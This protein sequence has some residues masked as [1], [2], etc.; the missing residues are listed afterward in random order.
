VGAPDHSVAGA[1]HQGA[2]YAFTRFG[3]VWLQQQEI[4]ASDGHLD[5]IF[6]ADVAMDSSTA[7]IKGGD[8]GGL[9][10]FRGAAY[11]FALSGGLWFEQQKLTADDSG[12]GDD[13]GGSLA[14]SGDTLVVGAAFDDIGANLSQG[15]VYVFIRTGSTWTLQQKLLA[16]DGA[17]FDDLGFDVA[18]S[19]DTIIAG[20]PGKTLPAIEE[21]GAA[22]V[23]SRA[24]TVWTQQQKLTASDAGEADGFGAGVA[25]SDVVI[26]GAPGHKVGSNDV[27]GAAYVF[28]VP[29]AFDFCMQDDSSGKLLRLNSKTGDYEFLDCRNGS[30]LSG[31]GSIA[32][33]SC[34]TQLMDS[35]TDPKHPDRLVS[36]LVNTCTKVASATVQTF[37]PVKKTVSLSDANITNN[38]CACQ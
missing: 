27:E 30:R 18:I 6:G 4:T 36:A 33:N 34:K 15:S 23:F 3:N 26:I 14:L 16:S 28:S 20:A 12:V 25:I 38:T 7:V 10:G 5:E 24:G 13:F 22:F 29:P 1:I 21:A 35:G 8:R 32:V 19:G 11:V 31:K 2:A 37:L 17:I 9:D